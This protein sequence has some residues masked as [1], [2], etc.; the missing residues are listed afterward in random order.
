MRR[1]F[2]DIAAL[3]ARL[4]LGGIFITNGWAK[5]EAGLTSTSASFEQIGA[6]MPGVW[7]ASTML[8][9]L[10]GGTL[11]IVGLI[12]PLA[13]LILFAEYAAIFFLSAD[14]VSESLATGG[15]NL[16]VALGA[17]AILLAALGAGRISLH[18]LVFRGRSAGTPEP[19]PAQPAPAQAAP[20]ASAPAPG[21]SAPGAPERPAATVPPG[22]IPQ[23]AARPTQGTPREAVRMDRPTDKPAPDEPAET[24]KPLKRPDDSTQ[25][26]R[27]PRH[28]APG[29]P[30]SGDMLVAG[31]RK[32]KR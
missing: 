2:I 18:H 7:A 10:I 32:Q 4:G 28:A 31:A 13:G 20:A 16:A 12:V 29:G 21:T 1:T 26:M 17:A 14:E 5:L 19:A 9:E 24:T 23:Q 22:T 11:L 30:D 15:V 8:V 27:R 6:P 3:A 25:T